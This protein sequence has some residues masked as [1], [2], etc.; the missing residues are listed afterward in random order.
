[1]RHYPDAELEGLVSLSE[2]VAAL[3]SAFG[4]LGR[5]RAAVQ[6]RMP[7]ISGEF[8]LNTMAAVLPGT[9]YCGAK[10]YTALGNHFSFV[11]LLFSMAD[12]RILATF[13]LA[14][15]TQVRTAAVSMLAAK[16]LARHDSAC[17]TVFGTGA[18]AA[19]QVA[20]LC[21]GLPITTVNVVSRNDATAFIERMREVTKVVVKQAQAAEAV[22]TADVIVTA[23]RAVMPLFDGR[24]VREGC[25]I[26]AVGSAQAD[27]TELDAACIG[28]CGK[29][30]VEALDHAQH[31]AGD[32]IQAEKAG[33]FSWGRAITL[34]DLVLSKAKGREADSEITLFKSV[35]SALEDLAVVEIAYEK[36]RESLQKK[37][38]S[39]ARA[40]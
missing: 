11:F 29:I 27:A 12:G 15:L 38:C 25:F 22:Q 40:V 20:A 10:V 13:D 16:Y 34:S 37:D 6:P 23:T 1:M 30:A 33:A 21:E 17:L 31:E 14:H 18:Q 3:S 8:R 4:E 39:H 7:T 5:G 35:G 9:G 19:G 28:R 2:A 32:L 24:L 36:L 26:I